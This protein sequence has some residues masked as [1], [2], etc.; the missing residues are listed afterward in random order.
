MSWG[1]LRQTVITFMA[2]PQ[3]GDMATTDRSDARSQVSGLDSI[4]IAVRSW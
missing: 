3:E 2:W 1:R 4:A